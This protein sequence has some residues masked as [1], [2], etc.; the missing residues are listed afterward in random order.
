MKK[1]TTN[2]DSCRQK[3]RRSTF[4]VDGK[5]IYVWNTIFLSTLGINDSWVQTALQKQGKG[6]V[7]EVDKRGK[8][9]L[10]RVRVDQKL[11][12]GIKNHIE[13]FPKVP[14]HY[15]RKDT[16]CEYLDERP[17][18]K[19]M[20][21]LYLEEM[22]ENHPMKSVA[23]ERQYRDIFSNY[24]FHFFK[25][26][27]DQWDVCFAWK[28]AIREDK[29]KTQKEYDAHVEAKDFAW[30]LKDQ[31]KAVA[32]LDSNV[33]VACYDLHKVLPCPRA[34]TSAFY[35]KRHLSISNF[36]VYDYTLNDGHCYVWNETIGHKGSN[37]IGSCVL[38]FIAKAT[39]SGVKALNLYSDNCAGQNRNRFVYAMYLFASTKYK[40][41]VT[42]RFLEVGHTQNE[43]DSMHALIERQSKNVSI[44]SPDD[45]VAIIKTAKTTKKPYTVI[46]VEQK[47]IFDL[48]YIVKNHNWEKDAKGKK[49]MWSKIREI[50]TSF[51][52]NHIVHFKYDFK[53]EYEKICV[54]QGC[55]GRPPN[56]ST[57][58]LKR[59]Y[60]AFLP[61]EKAKLK[62]LTTLCDSGAIP[63]SRHSFYQTLKSKD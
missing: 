40:V 39:L 62:D 56:L 48:K 7:L 4:R 29:L 14:S 2:W 12:Q 60:E 26:K 55:K 19:K 10:N 53:S 6:S 16:N 45:W 25:P 15:C 20:H 50:H 37:E 31:N 5:V 46:E 33:C 61:I 49:V 34:E 17:D 23:T 28:N 59:A 35:Y 47:Q 51:E 44:F 54:T 36:T 63:S 3:T 22:T 57:Y 13:S 58:K 21:V 1:R 24:N 38:D 30:G 11:I 32:K 43:G 8:S 18:V 52:S 41:S 42:H 9:S 27:K